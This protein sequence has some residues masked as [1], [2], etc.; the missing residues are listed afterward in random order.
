[1]KRMIVAAALTLACVS[2]FAQ[3]KDIVKTGLNFGPLPAVAFDADKG[4]QYGAILQIYNYGD[5]HNYPNYDSKTYIEYSRFT[6]GSQLIQLRYDDKELIPNVRWSS[7]LRIS[8]DKAYDFYGF[9]G[10]ESHY[11]QARITAGKNGEDFL[12]SP[13]Y[14]MRKN[15]YLFKSDFLGRINDKWQ[16]EAGIFAN[17]FQLGTIDY[18]NVNK[19]K[20]ASE[21]YPEAM[22]TLFD[23]YKSAG[24]ISAD[25]ADGGLASGVRAGIVYDTRDKEGAPTSG[26]WAEAHV[27]AALPG[28]SETPYARYSATWRQYF[29]LIGNNVLT[30][31]YRLNYEG[32]LGENAPFYALPYMTVMGEK[33]DLEGMGGYN[34]V[35]GIM[36]TR[37]LGLDMATYNAEFRW[38]FMRFN[39]G[40]QNIAL[41]L[42]AFSDGTM[43]TRG[44]DLKALKLLTGTPAA[45]TNSEKDHLHVTAGAGFRFIMN[46]NFIVAAEY[47]TPI[48]HFMKNSPVYNEDGTG[49]FYINLGYLF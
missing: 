1:M 22:T 47:G 6:K 31:A 33:C 39:L 9:N 12:F 23:I 41:G 4:F 18:A 44:R 25:E 13:F 42:S 17:Y 29:P 3:K 5:G 7:A 34:T 38:R 21:A 28:I 16:W 43:V 2:G 26:I 48:S 8:L 40:N 27:A 46:E 10:Y 30:F 32:T 45:V 36:R 20:E 19:G 37:V 35:R 15:E 24:V 49:A 14:R 11:D